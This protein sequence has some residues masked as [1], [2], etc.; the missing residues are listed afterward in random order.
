M[1]DLIISVTG[2]REV[3]EKVGGSIQLIGGFLMVT[4]GEKEV[5]EVGKLVQALEEFH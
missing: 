5:K 3:W 1:R 2:G 4:G